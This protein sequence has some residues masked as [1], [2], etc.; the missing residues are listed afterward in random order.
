MKE[1]AR[2]QTNNFTNHCWH[3]GFQ[4]DIIFILGNQLKPKEESKN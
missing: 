2:W 3:Q 4:E 1:M